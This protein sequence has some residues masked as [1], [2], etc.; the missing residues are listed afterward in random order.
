MAYISFRQSDQTE[1]EAQ[2]EK[3]NKV[4]NRPL[5]FHEV[6]ANFKAINDQLNDT[7]QTYGLGSGYQ[8]GRTLGQIFPEEGNDLDKLNK[9]GFYTT[10]TS[11][12][13]QPDAFDVDD[14]SSLIHV[15]SV[16]HQTSNDVGAFQ[17]VGSTDFPLYRARSGQTTWSDWHK[18]ITE[19]QLKFTLDNV[20]TYEGGYVEGSFKYNAKPATRDGATP[21]DPKTVGFEFFDKLGFKQPNRL[22]NIALNFA[23]T[24]TANYNNVGLSSYNP[25][26]SADNTPVELTV[27]WVVENG[28]PRRTAKLTGYD[29]NTTDINHLCTIEVLNRIVN[30]NT[31]L[32]TVEGGSVN[33]VVNFNESVT[34]NK[35]VSFTKGLTVTGDNILAN[36][37]EVLDYAFLRTVDVEGTIT[38][39]ELLPSIST[40]DKQYSVKYIQGFAS[41]DPNENNQLL[42]LAEFASEIS[43]EK[44]ATVSIGA[45]QPVLG[46]NN[47]AKI[48]ISVD[49]EGNTSTS[50]PTPKSQSNDGSIATTKWVTD[51]LNFKLDV[52]G[53]A[54]SAEIADQVPGSGVIGAVAEATHAGRADVAEK[55]NSV[56]WE[57]VANKPNLV[58][59]IN[60]EPPVNGNYDIP[61]PDLSKVLHCDGSTIATGTIQSS[62]S[63]GS[64]VS[65]ARG[66]CIL[67][68]TLGAGSFTPFF[69]Y[70]VQG[71]GAV[72]LAGYQG[73]LDLY[74]VNQTNIDSNTNNADWHINFN[75]D[76]ST[77]FPRTVYAQTFQS[78]S[79]IRKKENLIEIDQVDLTSLKSY[80]YNFKQDPDKVEHI[81]LIAQ[82][83]EQ[84]YPQ[85]VNE[86]QDGF[87]S[88]DYNG[89]VA[90]LVSKINSLEARIAQL[91]SK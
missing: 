39:S 35:P 3:K 72:T 73:G 81:G 64:W 49:S 15:E 23:R 36:E 29:V 4:L 76:G 48:T 63:E 59:T 86:D 91:E 56:I 65:G 22:G 52:D 17:L 5:T 89:I 27:G 30:K 85:L 42:E 37:I 58:M 77:R 61:T 7:K 18:L 55:A 1:T 40:F 80:K 34:F 32:S 57:N 8:D 9:S 88:I 11:T 19:K 13:N 62:R 25:V 66:A 21:C 38:S 83:V 70:K 51:K 79:D 41:S 43:P 47:I 6:D 54:P 75:G 33:G 78:T 16:D 60:G 46:S 69:N 10:T 45:K 53:K 74:Y 68:S 87:K 44:V 31:Y 84:S 71:G 28:T 26:D 24:E 82:Q 2:L 67:S 14:T 20:L 50:A 90:L 12:L